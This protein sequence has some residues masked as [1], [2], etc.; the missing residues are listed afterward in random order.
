MDRN[1]VLIVLD[2]VR[3]DYFDRYAS[4]LQRRGNLAFEQ[5][6]AASSWSTPSHA[7]MFVGGLPHQYGIHTYQ[8][9]FSG[10][11][12]DDTFL[13]RL[14]DHRSIGISSNFYIGSSHGFN[15]PFDEFVDITPRIRYPDSW[16]TFPS[17]GLS[18]YP[19]VV[20]RSIQSDKTKEYLSNAVSSVLRSRFD[21]VPL[22]SPYDD[23]AVPTVRVAKR[24]AETTSE[25]FFMFVNFMDVHQPLSPHLGLDNSRHSVKH[26]WSS[27]E[28]FYRAKWD[29][30]ARNRIDDHETFLSNYRALY[31]AAVEYVDR[32]ASALVDAVQRS[33]D[34]PTTFVITADHG[35]NLG[36]E[37]DDYR[38]EHTDSLSEALLHVPLCVIN[39]PLENDRTIDSYVSQARM[40]ELITGM[41]VDEV[42]DV[43]DESIAAEVLGLS[44]GSSTLSDAERREMDRT[45]RAAYRGAD[46]VLWDT[47]GKSAEYRIDLAVAS[48]QEH[49]DDGVD[50]PSWATGLFDEDIESARSAAIEAGERSTSDIDARAERRLQELGYL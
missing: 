38:F 13:G 17:D 3:K 43:T 26:S 20:L 48:S 4:E 46:K 24:R 7:S 2:S 22:P 35:E 27:T 34:R 31:G 30:N 42:P 37:G 23:G 45:I 47:H 25:P 18:R 10:L 14:D 33:S 5:A 41:A 29:I 9:S 39:A 15:G 16:E 6:R 21:G 8:R 11:S 32:K 49:L 1:V 19:K 44:P 36:F 12:R 28:E 50:V 40:G